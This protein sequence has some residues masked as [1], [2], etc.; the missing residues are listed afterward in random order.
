MGEIIY[1]KMQ[2]A[3][4]AVTIDDRSCFLLNQTIVSARHPGGSSPIKAEHF[5]NK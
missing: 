5:L 3:Y 4:G 1:S 2:E